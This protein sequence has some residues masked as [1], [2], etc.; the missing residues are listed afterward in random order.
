MRS[1]RSF[2]SS[3]RWSS[4]G[5]NRRPC[6]RRRRRSCARKPF[7]TRRPGGPL[8][9][10]RPLRALRAGIAWRAPARPC[11]LSRP[12]SRSRP[13]PRPG[14][15]A[16]PDIVALRPRRRRR[17]FVD[18]AGRRIQG[19]I[20]DDAGRACRSACF[21]LARSNRARLR[22]GVPCGPCEPVAPGAPVAPVSPLIPC[23][24]CAPGRPCRFSWATTTWC[25]RS[26]A[27]MPTSRRSMASSSPPAASV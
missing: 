25:S 20:A 1:R 17:L 2:R 27:I 23:G 15:P 26:A 10:R 19:P 21:R 14:C 11:R 16:G 12:A 4:R 5:T 6:R 24:P 18:V 3:R 7:L 22:P 8:R 13:G 9:A